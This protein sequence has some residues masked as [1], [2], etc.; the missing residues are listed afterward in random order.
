LNEGLFR[1]EIPGSESRFWRC[2]T[3][4]GASSETR[5]A[6]CGRTH[7]EYLP[8]SPS[9]RCR[10]PHVS[11][12]AG[13]KTCP[14]HVNTFRECLPQN[15]LVESQ[16]AEKVGPK[17]HFSL[18]VSKVQGARQYGERNRCTQNPGCR[19]IGVGRLAAH[20]RLRP[21]VANPRECGTPKNLKAVACPYFEGRPPA[22]CHRLRRMRHP[23]MLRVNPAEATGCLLTG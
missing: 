5:G 13:R 4:C 22:D 17:S 10:G 21:S 19:G 15:K 6:G 2:W 14:S 18:C 23:P 7:A 1:I 12:L 9:R 16:L 11:S 8:C 20:P 3:M